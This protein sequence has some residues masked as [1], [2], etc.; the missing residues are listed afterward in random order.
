MRK[1][2]Q[3]LISSLFISGLVLPASAQTTQTPSSQTPTL[4]TATETKAEK[5]A[6]EL[7]LEESKKKGEKVLAACLQDCKESAD[8]SSV[9]K[10]KAL[11]LP[12]PAYPP[13]A[14]AARV[15]GSVEVQVI[16]DT[17]GTVIAAA[18]VSGHPLLQAAS[19]A[20]ARHARFSPT[21]YQGEPVKVTG[22][23]QYGFALR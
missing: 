4:S 23:I 17:D 3:F 16:I 9:L 8:G 21:L 19:V 2:L 13:I 11:A 14:R 20:A 6:V 7:A 1:T 10:G 22:V 18:A 5:N 15:S 12:T